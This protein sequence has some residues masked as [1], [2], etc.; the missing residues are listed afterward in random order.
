V[1]ELRRRHPTWGARK[2]Y[3]YAPQ[4]NGQPA[5]PVPSAIGELLRREGLTIPRRRPIRN[6]LNPPTQ[7]MRE[8]GAF[9]WKHQDVFLSETLIGERIELQAIDDRY[10]LVQFAAF[11]IAC[12]DSQQLIIELLPDEDDAD[13]HD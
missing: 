8:R 13:D 7:P 6:H 10:W 9:S 4:K 3:A 12:F 11:P 5:W 1:L 2:L